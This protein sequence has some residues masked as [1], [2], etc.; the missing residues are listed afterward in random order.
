[1]GGFLP[2]GSASCCCFVTKTID[3]TQRAASIVV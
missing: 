2:S 3:K 1:M